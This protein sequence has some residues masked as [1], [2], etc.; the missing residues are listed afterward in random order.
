MPSSITERVL[1]VE[2]LNAQAGLASSAACSVH[3]A[4]LAVLLSSTVDAIAAPEQQNYS[5]AA[6]I[7]T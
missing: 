3:T 1:R 6:L 4:S 5:Y 7:I 2:K